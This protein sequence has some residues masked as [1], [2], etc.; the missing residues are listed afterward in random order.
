MT[1]SLSDVLLILAAV[2]LAAVGP[3]LVAWGNR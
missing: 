3:T 1:K 2:A